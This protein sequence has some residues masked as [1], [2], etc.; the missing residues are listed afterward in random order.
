MYILNKHIFS[1]SWDTCKFNP[2]G[3][4]YCKRQV[5]ATQFICAII[6]SNF[7]LMQNLLVLG[8]MFRKHIFK[9]NLIGDFEAIRFVHLPKFDWLSRAKNSWFSLLWNDEALHRS[10]FV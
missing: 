9:V 1:A 6:I 7:R 5:S 2:T 3:V 4:F 8:S 10:G